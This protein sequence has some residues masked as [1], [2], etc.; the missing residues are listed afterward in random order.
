MAVE[1]PRNGSIGLKNVRK[2][3]Q[4][5]YPGTHE[6]NIVNEPESFIVFLKI[7]LQGM[8]PLTTTAEE[9]QTGNYE[10]A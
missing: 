4:L 3:L 9:M 5:L 8:K 7:Q 2:R 1:A 6:L 10:L